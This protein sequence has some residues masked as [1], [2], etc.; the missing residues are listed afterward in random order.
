MKKYLDSSFILGV[1][2]L[3]LGVAMLIKKE[4]FFLADFLLGFANLATFYSKNKKK[5]TDNAGNS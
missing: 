3:I 4:P 1:V 5:G 2:L